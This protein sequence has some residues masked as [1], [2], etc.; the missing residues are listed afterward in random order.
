MSRSSSKSRTAGRIR[1][2]LLRIPLI[3]LIVPLK[4]LLLHRI[5]ST[6]LGTAFN[7]FLLEAAV[8]TLPRTPLLLCARKF[9]YDG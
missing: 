8:G 7:V 4:P 2:V 9:A 6:L 1:S 5:R 3:P